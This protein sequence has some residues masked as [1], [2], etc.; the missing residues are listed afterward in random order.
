MRVCIE[1]TGLYTYPDV[2]VV[3]GPPRFQDSY[4]DTLRNAATVPSSRYLLPLD[5]GRRSW[6]QVPPTTLEDSLTPRVC[7][8]L[9]GQN[10]RGAIRPA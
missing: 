3:C 6:D 7:P 10:A 9:A 5:R 4:V 8:D 2:V 1:A